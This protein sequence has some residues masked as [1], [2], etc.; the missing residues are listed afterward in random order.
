MGTVT[1]LKNS[2]EAVAFD[3]TQSASRSGRWVR[4]RIKSQEEGQAVA[5]T[6]SIKTTSL[7]RSRGKSPALDDNL[8]SML[9][10]ELTSHKHGFAEGRRSHR[11][12]RGDVGEQA[13]LLGLGTFKGI[14]CIN[15]CYRSLLQCSTFNTRIGSI[16]CFPPS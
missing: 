2:Q 1:L 4:I 9:E 14:A 13:L 12:A 6:I 5:W 10:N 11:H 3:W 15:V 16:Y 8:M 7:V